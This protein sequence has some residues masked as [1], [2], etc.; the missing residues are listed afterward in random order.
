MGQ[1]GG[2]R[3]REP[4]GMMTASCMERTPTTS[5]EA[6]D[7]GQK[8]QVA[9]IEDGEMIGMASAIRERSPTRAR[10]GTVFVVDQ[11]RRRGVARALLR[12]L[13][14]AAQERG[15]ALLYGTTSSAAPFTSTVHRMLTDL[16]WTMDAPGDVLVEGDRET[17]Q[18]WALLDPGVTF[19]VEFGPLADITDV[20]RAELAYRGAKNEYPSFLGPFPERPIEPIN[21][22]VARRN[23]R[24][25]GWFVTHRVDED[26]ILFARLFVLKE[27]RRS[28]VGTALI[29]EAIVRQYASPVPTVHTLIKADNARMLAFVEDY[30]TPFLS[31][32]ETLTRFEKQLAP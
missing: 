22:L 20:E 6:T 4:E 30:A 18:G 26:S 17:I 8:L 3:R 31:R 9:A 32:F 13:E 15:I 21:S 24:I 16:G 14:G 27:A 23:G 7:V 2:E 11:A 29:R 10:I 25:A 12:A 5:F 19:D 28:S 1:S